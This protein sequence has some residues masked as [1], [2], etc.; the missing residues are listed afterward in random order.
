MKSKLLALSAAS[1]AATVSVFGATTSDTQGAGDVLLG[2]YTASGTGATQNLIVNLGSYT[3]FESNNGA[4]TNFSANI[5]A[6]LAATYGASWNSRTDLEWTVTGANY[7][8]SINGLTRNTIFST[9]PRAQIGDAPTSIASGSDSTLS[10]VRVNI[11]AI[12]NTYNNTDT[13]VNGTVNVIVDGTNSDSLYARQQTANAAQFGPNTANLA[14][15]TSIS[16][17]YGLVPTSGGT[18]P[19]G[20]STDGS[21]LVWARGTNYLGYFTLS[22]SGLSFTASG[23]SAIP[24]PSS[25]AALCGLA[26]MGYV[27]AGRRRR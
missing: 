14:T 2:F 21:G 12:A 6:D 5:V 1:I 9:S 23:T 13:T 18:A 24:E 26:V 11:Q 10:A 22:N 7:T 3:Q 15:G 27:A 19:T 20:L 4:T 8:S 17:F 25:Y 16:D